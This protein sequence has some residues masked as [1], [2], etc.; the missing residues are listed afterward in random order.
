MDFDQVQIIGD[1]FGVL[2]MIPCMFLD[3]AYQSCVDLWKAFGFVIGLVLYPVMKLISI[4]SSFFKPGTSDMAIK[5]FS[6]AAENTTNNSQAA[7]QSIP[8]PEWESFTFAGGKYSHPSPDDEDV[9]LFGVRFFLVVGVVGF[10]LWYFKRT[11]RL[12]LIGAEHIY[13]RSI[14]KPGTKMEIKS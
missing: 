3:G 6:V 10:A 13:R 4:F 2:G 5:V 9:P 11:L 1:F 14:Q 12:F 8:V 7:V